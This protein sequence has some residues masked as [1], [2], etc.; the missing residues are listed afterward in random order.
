M[1]CFTVSTSFYNCGPSLFFSLS[2]LLFFLTCL[3]RLLSP[4]SFLCIFLFVLNRTSIFLFL[5]FSL[6]CFPSWIYLDYSCTNPPFPPFLHSP[7]TFHLLWFLWRGLFFI[8]TSPHWVCFVWVTD[9]T[10]FFFFLFSFS[11]LSLISQYLSFFPLRMTWQWWCTRPFNK[12][13]ASSV[14]VLTVPWRLI[15]TLYVNKILSPDPSI[16][17]PTEAVLCYRVSIRIKSH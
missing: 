5:P 2:L 11:L 6:R 16:S 7:L 3:L 15:H 8:I 12:I 10:S 17:P 1:V 13:L 9:P 4:S 14:H